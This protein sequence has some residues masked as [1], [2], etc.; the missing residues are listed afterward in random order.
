MPSNDSD[1]SILQHSW[2]A[3]DVLSSKG[4]PLT[5]VLKTHA[6]HK[7]RCLR[8]GNID[9][10]RDVF[11]FN[12][13][14]GSDLF[15]QKISEVP[16]GIRVCWNSISLFESK[17]PRKL[18]GLDTRPI[19]EN[20]EMAHTAVSVILKGTYWGRRCLSKDRYL[21]ML[22][23]L[24]TQDFTTWDINQL[25]KLKLSPKG[26]NYLKS[27][28]STIDGLCIQLVL[29][30]PDCPQIQNWD[31]FDNLINCCF[32]NL[33]KDW[34]GNHPP[35]YVSYYEKLKTLRGE[36]KRLAFNE[37]VGLE[38]IRVPREM[39]FLR[40][41]LSMIKIKS[42]ESMFRVALLVQTRACGTP[43]PHVYIKTFQKFRETVTSPCS[44]P[45]RDVMAKLAAATK[46]VYE[47]IVLTP[48]QGTTLPKRVN[49][50]LRKAKISLSDNA[51]LSTPSKQG[52]K[53]EAFRKLY[54]SIKDDVY[55]VDMENGQ[56]TDEIVPR[57]LEH[58]GTRVFHY[59]FNKALYNQ[60][61]DLM[62][63][64]CEGVLEP[65][66]VREITISDIYHVILLHPI[67]HVLLD[68]LA[69]V[70]SSATGIKAANHAFEFYKRLNHKNPR[71]NFIFNE[72][73]LWVLSSD[74]ETATD[75]ANPHI[76][77]LILHVFMGT[78]G[79]GVPSAYR[80]MVMKLLTEPRLVIDPHSNGDFMTTRGC[81]MGDP[82][83][84]FVMH[85]MHLVAK[86]IALQLVNNQ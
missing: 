39:T 44:V 17:L 57:D 56:L 53:Y 16:K 81:L 36:I 55:Y 11:Y 23:R 59:C 72:T 54:N 76:V 82:V 37:Q 62:T 60:H 83:T 28:L 42:I 75:Y 13:T 3:H 78:H 63:V 80:F 48:L 31:Y 51:E 68:V 9:T 52:G 25:N 79:L 33:L 6:A 14:I 15:T 41:P 58:M 32:K 84:K 30:F 49:E 69:L 20:I 73:D 77:R 74:L 71:G 1:T 8:E 47:R 34:M 61:A 65:G 64:R 86:E 4:F 50:A 22:Y 67:S 7:C 66:K 38:D 29:A 18:T 40:K 26:V 46:V 10:H 24:L 21:P 43:P 45:P 19:F 70:P 12:Q 5:C 2:G 35:E 85:L 27:I